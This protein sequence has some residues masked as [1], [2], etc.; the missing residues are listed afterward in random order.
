MDLF[1]NLLSESEPEV[2]ELLDG[3]SSPRGSSAVLHRKAF[4]GEQ[5]TQ[6][7]RTLLSDVEWEQ[8]EITVYGKTHLQPRLVAWF[9]DPGTSYT[10]AGLTLHPTPWIDPIL[11]I[12]AVCEV[13]AGIAFNSV[14]L[15]LYRDGN[16]TVGW[17]SDDEPELG[18][19]P[20]HCLGEPWCCTSL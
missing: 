7:Y 4:T 2:E 1:D 17:H 18:A 3:I 10:Y 9:G 6:L 13:V 14:L 5:S 16:D 19:K 15:N 12:K 8:R 11:Q 20:H